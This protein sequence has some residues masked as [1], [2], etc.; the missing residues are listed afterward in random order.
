MEHTISL[1]TL[2]QKLALADDAISRITTKLHLVQSLRDSISNQIDA[3]V[4]HQPSHA[5]LYPEFE[6]VTRTFE[7]N[8][9]LNISDFHTRRNDNTLTEEQK[10]QLEADIYHFHET[11]ARIPPDRRDFSTYAVSISPP[12]SPEHI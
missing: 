4:L 12:S 3:I 11:D 7:T 2:Q 9:W 1:F 5:K 6:S 10:L 8:Y